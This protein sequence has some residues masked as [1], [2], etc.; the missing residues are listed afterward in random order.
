[1]P[2]LQKY[3]VQLAFS[4]VFVGNPTLYS[5]LKIPISTRHRIVLTGLPIKRNPF[6]QIA[7]TN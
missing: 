5:A 3:K 2:R 7:Q 1:M 4:K 6:E